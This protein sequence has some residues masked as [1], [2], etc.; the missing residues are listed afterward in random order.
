VKASELSEAKE[1]EKVLAFERVLADPSPWYNDQTYLDT[2][3]EKAVDRFVE[4]GPGRVLSG[5]IR[6]IDGSRQ[7]VSLEDL[8]SLERLKKTFDQ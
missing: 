1:G 2:I 3:S 7:I 6:R 5:L 4:V 8:A